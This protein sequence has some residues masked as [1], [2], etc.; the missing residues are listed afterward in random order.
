MSLQYIHTTQGYRKGGAFLT[1]NLLYH[2]TL[3]FLFP[4]GAI[5]FAVL[6]RTGYLESTQTSPNDT[7]LLSDHSRCG[8]K[9]RRGCEGSQCF[10]GLNQWFGCRRTGLSTGWERLH[11]E[12]LTMEQSKDRYLEACTSH[13]AYSCQESKKESRW[14]KIAGTS[15]FVE[16]PPVC[17]ILNRLTIIPDVTSVHEDKHVVCVCQQGR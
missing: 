6:W 1:A 2:M 10:H 3:K 16:L 11:G 7:C 13:A 15:Y 9:L 17:T 4:G 14:L 5:I 8:G 12:M